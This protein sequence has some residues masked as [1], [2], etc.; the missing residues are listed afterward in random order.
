MINNLLDRTA[1]AVGGRDSALH[2]LSAAGYALVDY[3]QLDVSLMEV[4][5]P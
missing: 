2:A 4:M 1:P 5:E 3:S